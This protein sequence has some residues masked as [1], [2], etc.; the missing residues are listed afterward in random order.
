VTSATASFTDALSELQSTSL[1]EILSANRLLSLATVSPDG[2]AHINTAFFAFSDEFVLYLLSPTTSEHA[3]NVA[4]NPSA[5]LA[6]FDSHQTRQRR[7]G[8]Q[9]FG[10]LEEV[11]PADGD[12]ALACFRTRFTD[13]AGEGETYADVVLGHGSALYAF[14]PSR[15]KLFD[16]ALLVADEY[17]EVPPAD[18]KRG[19]L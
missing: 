2:N 7:R 16:E 11:D 9:L 3:G 15:V 8:A 12:S 14:H 4:A 10:R 19:N 6:V 18:G 5:A 17:V 1:R 13:V